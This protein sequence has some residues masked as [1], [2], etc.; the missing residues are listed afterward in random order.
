MGLAFNKDV[1][2][3]SWWGKIKVTFKVKF[4]IDVSHRSLF[5]LHFQGELLYGTLPV[6]IVAFN[7]IYIKFHFFHT[8]Q[9]MKFSVKNI[10]SKFELI[11][12][13]LRICLHLLKISL[14]ESIFWAVLV[15]QNHFDS[16]MP[17][18]NKMSFIYFNKPAAF[19]YLFMLSVFNLFFHPSH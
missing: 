9:R 14:S 1:L 2:R 6:T 13:K 16:S 18:R 17:G 8:V 3:F 4:I 5:S 19:R 12:R 15:C 7:F 11:R 10:F